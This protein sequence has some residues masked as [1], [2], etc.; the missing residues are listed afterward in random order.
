VRNFRVEVLKQTIFGTWFKR[1]AAEEE[2]DHGGKLMR[3]AMSVIFCIGL[4]ACAY[5]PELSDEDELPV[6][7][8]L[9]HAICELKTAF[10]QLE[11]TPGFKAKE[12]AI[13]ISL[14]PKT[15]IELAANI[16]ATYK[17]TFNTKALNFNTWT[18]GSPGAQF[19]VKGHRDGSVTFLVHSSQLFD[20]K[21]PVICPS[22]PSN[23]SFMQKLGI[24]EWLARLMTTD[25]YGVSKITN[26][27]KPTYNSEII[28][29][30]DVGTAGATFFG[31]Y[32]SITPSVLG[33]HTRDETLSIAMTPDPVKH[34]IQT[35]PI[36]NIQKNFAGPPPSIISLGARQRLDT[37]QTDSIL[38]NLRFQTE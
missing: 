7:D 3:R 14:T 37:I 4:S 9:T 30:F 33:A 24:E 28:I 36:G 38:R 27:D 13:S 16:G 26:M 17:S 15:D 22:G 8:I 10:T 32:A 12:W 31:P 18:L 5:I 1:L 19:D 21:H 35:L 2:E 23:N 20:G 11:S 25:E 34:H 6:Q 29:K